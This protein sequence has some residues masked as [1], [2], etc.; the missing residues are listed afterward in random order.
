MMADSTLLQLSLGLLTI[1][2]SGLTSSWVTHRL[3]KN[4]NQTIFLRQKAETLYLAADEY[5]MAFAGNMVSYFPLLD[6]RYDYNAML[7]QQNKS[8]DLNQ[9][10]GG[11]KAMTMIVDIYFPTVRPALERVWEARDGFNEVTRMIRSAWIAAEHQGVS[12]LRSQFTQASLG[13]DEAINELKREI[14][15]AA[16]IQSGVKQ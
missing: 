4:H 12:Q 2:G 15:L 7:D 13:F 14:V 16:R 1:V 3:N 10:N 9:E 6:G 11:A 8:G 5:G